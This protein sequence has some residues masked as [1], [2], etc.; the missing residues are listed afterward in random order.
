[1][2]EHCAASCEEP[3]GCRLSQAQVSAPAEGFLPCRFAGSFPRRGHSSPCHHP[4][5]QGCLWEQE[6]LRVLSLAPL[7]RK[8]VAA[9]C[10]SALPPST[11]GGR[12]VWAG[13]GLRRSQPQRGTE[14]GSAGQHFTLWCTKCKRNLCHS[15]TCRTF[16][17]QWNH[18]L[19]CS[20]LT[21]PV[22][23]VTE[24]QTAADFAR[25]IAQS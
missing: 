8:E 1:M 10:A 19:S 6:T 20:Q 14:Q 15:S 13:R 3:A 17:E 2:W 16:L 22:F 11:E 4:G 24:S 18:S 21:A 25:V 5:L 9:P 7:P 12:M 23:G